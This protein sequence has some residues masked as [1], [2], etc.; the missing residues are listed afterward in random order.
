MV[1]FIFCA[2]LCVICLLVR[3]KVVKGEL[4]GES[5][6][7]IGSLIFL[8]SLWFFYIIMSI[9]QAYEIG[10]TDFWSKLTFGIEKAN[11]YCAKKSVG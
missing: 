9:L 11:D 10:G 8:V 2:V 1:V 6:G 4:G 5:G 3:R 7:R